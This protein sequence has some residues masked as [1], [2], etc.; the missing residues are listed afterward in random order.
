MNS[1]RNV[2]LNLLDNTHAQLKIYREFFH[3]IIHI[4]NEM[5]SF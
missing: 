4:A 1:H 2:V 3:Y 5:T